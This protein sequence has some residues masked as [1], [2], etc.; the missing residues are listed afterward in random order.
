MSLSKELITEIKKYNKRFNNKD[1]T[2]NYNLREIAKY[3]VYCEEIIKLNKNKVGLTNIQFKP[4]E[5]DT[6][7]FV[8][9]YGQ[10]DQVS[11]GLE[12]D[13]T[14]V[15]DSFKLSTIDFL[16]NNNFTESK[17][18]LVVKFIDDYSIF[19]E[20]IEFKSPIYLSIAYLC[21]TNV[22]KE[23]RP[24]QVLDPFMENRKYSEVEYNEEEDDYGVEDEDEDYGDE[25]GED[26]DYGDEFGEDEDF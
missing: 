2:E 11:F 17:I 25:F 21:I 14:N 20:P 15:I 22:K 8:I 26:E 9:G 13:P 12:L 16:K 4:P 5:D 23:D 6:S 1:Q 3:V 10:L 24:K 19:M 18:N 7:Q